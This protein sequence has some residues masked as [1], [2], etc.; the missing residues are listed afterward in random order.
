MFFAT[1]EHKESVGV[2]KQKEDSSERA[3]RNGDGIAVVSTKS[4]AIN[5]WVSY[6]IM[7]WWKSHFSKY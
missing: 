7:K 5:Q 2:A 6:R 4:R 3:G 1:V